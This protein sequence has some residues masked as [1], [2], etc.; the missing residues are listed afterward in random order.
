[1]DTDGKTC[2]TCKHGILHEQEC[3]ECEDE[4]EYMSEVEACN[5]IN[6]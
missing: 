3:A 6:Q 5:Y 2:G 1:M 4:A